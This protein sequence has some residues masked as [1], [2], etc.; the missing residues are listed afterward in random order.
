MSAVVAAPP[1]TDAL[2][3]NV[4]DEGILY[5][6][7][8]RSYLVH[9]RGAKVRLR[10]EVDGSAGPVIDTVDLHSA[11][12]RKGFAERLAGELNPSQANVYEQDLLQIV[13]METEANAKQADNDAGPERVPVARL[14]G[15]IDLV[16]DDGRVSFLLR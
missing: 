10:V 6:G 9:K 8:G 16:L 14:D 12:A 2:T 1:A 4:T 7:G 5:E 15:L 11:R 3:R 13:E